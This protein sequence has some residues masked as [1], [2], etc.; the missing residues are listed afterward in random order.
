[1]V[2]A[3]SEEVTKLLLYPWLESIGGMSGTAPT[4]LDIEVVPIYP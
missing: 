2:K 4:I 3:H 1:M